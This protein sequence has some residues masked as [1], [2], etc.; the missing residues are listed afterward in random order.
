MRN[1]RFRLPRK[2]RRLHPHRRAL[3]RHRRAALRALRN[4]DN[5]PALQWVALRRVLHPLRRL[6]RRSLK[7]RLD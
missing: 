5:L 7:S 3:R 2:P 6:P 1:R 4:R